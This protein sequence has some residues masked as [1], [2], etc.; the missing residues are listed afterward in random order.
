MCNGVFE[1]DFI[2]V[3]F[4]E[5]ILYFWVVVD[6]YQEFVFN[7]VQL[8]GYFVILIVIK[9]VFFVIVFVFEVW[10]IEIKECVWFIIVLDKFGLVEVFEDNIFKVEVGCI[11]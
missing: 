9:Y 7:V 6:G 2:D 5:G 4:F 3:E 8:F 1:V 11:K 10:W